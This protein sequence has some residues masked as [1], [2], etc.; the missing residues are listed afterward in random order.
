MKQCTKCKVT[1]SLIDFYIETSRI[2][3]HKNECKKCSSK[4]ALAHSRTREGLCKVIFYSQIKSS[5]KR[6]HNPPTYTKK[7][8]IKWMLSQFNFESLY[9]NWVKSHYA[10]LYRPSC[11]RINNSKGY[12]LD[13]IQLVTWQKNDTRQ[14]KEL[15]EGVAPSATHKVTCK[16]DL[17]GNFIEEY[18]SATDASIKNKAHRSA[19][20]SVCNSK[21][22]FNTA[23]GYYWRYKENYSIKELEIEIHNTI[24]RLK[25]K[26]HTNA[27]KVYQFQN[28]ICINTFKSITE[29]SKVSN[30]PK[31]S[32][33]GQCSGLYIK[34]RLY[35]KYKWRFTSK[36]N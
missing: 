28:G 34:S 23:V 35:P 26:P 7:E 15:K 1:K 6:K 22:G 8:L 24:I 13:N 16:F 20:M 11:D 21:Y 14:R 31:D 5:V 2:D 3:G 12:S 19:I 27:K 30:V 18:V 4:T 17:N 32:I 29:A 9:S 25:N 10:K 33:R 36:L